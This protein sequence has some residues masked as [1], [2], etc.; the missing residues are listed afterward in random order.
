MTKI[1]KHKRQ[2]GA[3]LQIVGII[4]AI[5]V[6]T[7]II[8]WLLIWTKPQPQAA[9]ETLAPVKVSIANVE[10]RS[11]QPRETITG[12]LQPIK[13]AQIRFEVAGKVI[14]RDVEP[15]TTVNT[16]EVLM[17][18]DASDYLDQL[19]QVAAELLIEQKGVSRDKDL[20]KYA[21]NNLQLQQQE[22]KRLQRL[23]ERNLIAQSQLDS[24]RQRVFDLQA[25]VARLD[26]SVATSSARVRMKKAQHDIAKRNFTRTILAAA[27]DGVVNE[28]FVDEGDY[29][30]AN[31]IALTLVDVSKFDVQLDV[32]GEVIAGLQLG[33]HV[34]VEANGQRL[35]GELVAMQ[36]DPD[37]NT[38][39]H[40]V[41]VRVPNNNVQS[42]MLATVYMPLSAQTD[43]LLIPI[44]AVINEYGNSYVFIINDNV[45][46]KTPIKLGRRISNEVVVLDNL[47]LGQQ[48][49][50]RDVNSLTDQQHV[51][52][53]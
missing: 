41:R 25:E 14:S 29:V 30:N 51:T 45:V 10:K 26:Y 6:I 37:I 12:R 46:N 43:S 9:L 44:S 2:K 5:A 34:E 23:V 3:V 17:K 32:R 52:I 21:Q 53:E 39:T 28:V 7:I 49:V 8:V 20:L 42:G 18:L 40:H 19:Q 27:F 50:A 13:T 15:G 11:V 48:I 1:I 35:D 33:Q 47:V 38:N 16:G 31:E 4:T 22:E 24:T 36:L